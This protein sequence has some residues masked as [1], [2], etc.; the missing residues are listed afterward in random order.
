LKIDKLDSYILDLKDFVDP[1][2]VNHLD[3]R[4]VMLIL[5]AIIQSEKSNKLDSKGRLLL[6]E[7]VVEFRW[8]DSSK[9]VNLSPAKTKGFGR[10]EDSGPLDIDYFF[11]VLYDFELNYIYLKPFKVDKLQSKV[12]LKELI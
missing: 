10:S 5:D 12:S 9:N 1:S 4:A 6:D 2:I 7:L 3:G 8:I 11:G